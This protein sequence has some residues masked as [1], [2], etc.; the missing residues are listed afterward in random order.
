MQI[1]VTLEPHRRGLDEDG[2]SPASR[3]PLLPPDRAAPSGGDGAELERQG[4]S[5][6]DRGR[7]PTSGIKTAPA[8]ALKLVAYGVS[9]DGLAPGALPEPTP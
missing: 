6:T 2:A 3:I 8:L 4:W 7:P 1:A 5:V 9:L